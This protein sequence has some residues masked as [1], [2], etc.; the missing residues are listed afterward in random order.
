[1]SSVLFN[2]GSYNRNNQAR[3]DSRRLET[4]I[5]ELEKKLEEFYVIIAMLQKSSGSQGPA[6]PAGP[7]GPKGDQGPAGS[8]GPKGD[9]GPAGPKGDQGPVGPVAPAS[10]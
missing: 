6:G 3:A 2:G 4:K 7:A 1:M 5:A 8:A 9:Q 10:L